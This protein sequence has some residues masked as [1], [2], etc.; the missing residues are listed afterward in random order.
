MWVAPVLLVLRR[1]GSPEL[2]GLTLSAATL[3]ALVT[4]PLIGAWLDV[5][6]RRRAAI[7]LNQVVL[8]AGLAGL[9]PGPAAGPPPLAAPARPAPPPVPGR[10]PPQGPPTR[11]GA[12]GGA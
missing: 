7:A 10:V 12:P 8:A 3:P 4:A 6:G 2:A 9:L 5:H 1:T 11:C